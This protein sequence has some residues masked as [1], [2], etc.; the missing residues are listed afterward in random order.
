MPSLSRLV[1][2]GFM[3]AGKSTV[4]AIAAQTLGWEFLD[5]DTVIET[6]SRLSVGEIFRHH[7][8]ADFRQREQRALEQLSKRQGIV[9]ALGGG[10][11]EDASS[12]SLLLE[13]PGTCLVFLEGD[14]SELIA[15]CV[16]EGKVRPLLAAPEVMQ[17]RHAYRLPFYRMAHITV[18]TTG[19]APER[20]A[21]EMLSQVSAQW[22]MTEE[23]RS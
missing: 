8:E 13:T 10:T 16:A 14:L 15:R 20:V 22:Q 9:L 2:T 1:L 18:F 17:A 12:R 3:G 23:R 4:G 19:L 6:S 5:L 21:A 11:V 7:G